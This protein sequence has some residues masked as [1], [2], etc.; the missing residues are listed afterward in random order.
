MIGSLVGSY[1]FGSYKIFFPG[2]EEE[3]PADGTEAEQECDNERGEAA[4]AERLSSALSG[5]QASRLGLKALPSGPLQM[6]PNKRDVPFS[7]RLSFQFRL[8]FK[9]NNVQI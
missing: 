4:R 1:H 5:S 3:E 2:K 6:R 9:L 7:F 8:F